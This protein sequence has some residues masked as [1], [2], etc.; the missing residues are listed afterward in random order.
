ME[1]LFPLGFGNCRGT[2]EKLSGMQNISL[3]ILPVNFYFDCVTNDLSR[4]V[5]VE[6]VVMEQISIKVD[7]PQNLR[8]LAG[9]LKEDNPEDKIPYKTKDGKKFYTVSDLVQVHEIYY[10]TTSSPSKD[11]K[12]KAKSFFRSTGAQNKYRKVCSFSSI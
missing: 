7:K 11:S 10:N 4:H 8:V 3:E 9:M 6:G 1:R 12:H 5:I 2:E